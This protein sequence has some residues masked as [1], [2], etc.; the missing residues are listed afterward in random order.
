MITEFGNSALAKSDGI[1]SQVTF[2]KEGF[3]YISEITA[4][5]Q[6]LFF[7]AITIDNGKQLW[8][9]DGTEEGTKIV[10]KVIPTGVFGNLS[11]LKAFKNYAIFTVDL[12]EFGSELWVSDG[13]EDGTY[14][15]KD[16]EPGA[17][18][19]TVYS[20]T[21]NENYLFFTAENSSK[22][23]ELWRTDGTPEG[24][25]ALTD[26]ANNIDFVDISQQATIN[27]IIYF[28]V[29]DNAV[30]GFFI[31]QSDGSIANTKKYADEVLIS[32]KPSLGV[33]G[34]VMLNNELYFITGESS[35]GSWRLWKK[36]Q[37]DQPYELIAEELPEYSFHI[38]QF[39]ATDNRLFMIIGKS[40][41]AHDIWSSDGTT[42]NTKFVTANSGFSAGFQYTAGSDKLYFVD[43]HLWATDGTAEGT[44]QISS[45]RVYLDRLP[46]FIIFQGDLFFSG[47]VQS[48]SFFR[49]YEL[50]KSEGTLE[51]TT[52]LA[53]INTTPVSSAIWNLSVVGNTMFFSALDESAGMEP[54]ISDGTE[55]GTRLLKDLFP[56]TQDN[57]PNSSSPR[58]FVAF[59]DQAYFTALNLNTTSNQ[60]HKGL[61]K[62]DG[63]AEGTVVVKEIWLNSLDGAYSGKVQLNDKLYF[64]AFE[65]GETL[66]SL[67]SS[68][69]T[70]EGTIKLEEVGN[71]S[72]FESIGNPGSLTK[73]G[74][75]IFFVYENYDNGKELWKT[76]D[77]NQ[78]TMVKDIFPGKEDGFSLFEYEVSMIEYN[79]EL[80]FAAN[81]G[82]HGVELWKSDGTKD[83]TVM[84]RDIFPGESGSWAN[85]LTV[86]NGLVYFMAN[87][88][89][90]SR[91]LWKTDGT[92]G[93]TQ[94]VKD[95][96]Q[97]NV[98]TSYTNN[99]F[100]PFN[101]LLF[102]TNY[103]DEHG[104]ELWRTDGTGEG[105]HLFKDLY[106]GIWSNVPSF[107]TIVND[108]MYFTGRS[109]QGIKIWKTD[110]TPENTFVIEGFEEAG[111]ANPRSLTAF[112]DDL[113]F[114]ALDPLKGQ[115]LFKYK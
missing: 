103:D 107:L 97:P 111:L 105:T 98:N 45:T 26:V 41:N 100:F 104:W 21:S 109:D 67:W 15:L 102:F 50:F 71:S 39:L 90:N 63:T 96:G 34:P 59:N 19:S 73:F 89:D 54:W 2:V 8:R 44:S 80:L 91:K 35:S 86:Y 94:V 87:D 52:L 1:S 76:N 60:I 92:T 16:I 49:Q 42:E 25:I 28:M 81:D 101:D 17:N 4:T 30:G 62:S 93:G 108:I 18:G 79:G 69:G 110:G 95:F 84:I 40:S 115:S 70:E 57:H 106:P 23:K 32:D 13:T 10:K 114:T 53:D 88:S 14:I 11:N 31:W 85:Q 9:S 61:W 72:P 68:D 20:F 7:I 56:G 82:V 5:D 6:Y 37:L 65:K 48:T 75:S 51:S 29:Y 83:G 112:K 33:V 43:R 78:I 3:S 113:Y 58:N 55:T 22:G 74:N 36:P 24:T 46:F 38:Q 66:Y 47:Q 27:G 77:N 64:A 12:P 99:G